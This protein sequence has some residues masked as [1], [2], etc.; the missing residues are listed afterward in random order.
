MSILVYIA[1]HIIKPALIM[2]TIISCIVAA[3]IL[4]QPT[5]GQNKMRYNTRKIRKMIKAIGR[6]KT[7]DLLR[8]KGLTFKD[9]GIM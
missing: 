3:Y 6:T 4:T 5:K 1:M 7:A 2:A 8:S 9:F